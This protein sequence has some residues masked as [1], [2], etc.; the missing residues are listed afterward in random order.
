MD[1]IVLGGVLG[2]AM[3]VL[4]TILRDLVPRRLRIASD[5]TPWV[6][7]R[8]RRRTVRIALA[9]GRLV[10]IAGAVVLLATVLLVLLGTGDGIALAVVTGLTLVGL[11]AC[12]GWVLWYRYQE[13]SGTI[14]RRQ[15]RLIASRLGPA[16][17]PATSRP[18]PVRDDRPAARED[19][20][21]VHPQE[22]QRRRDAD[23][24]DRQPRHDRRTS[25]EAG[26][27]T[28]VVDDLLSRPP[29]RRGNSSTRGDLQT[30]QRPTA[31]QHDRS[32]SPR[33]PPRDSHRGATQPPV[34]AERPVWDTPSTSR[35]RRSESRP[36]GRAPRS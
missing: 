22:R 25:P 20:R 17:R 28:S 5:D 32:E 13:S 34:L 31:P 23:R 15:M 26:R 1:F 4:G 7:V 21:P 11:A 10:T 27:S 35:P 30:N 18:I 33:P 29:R 14:Q 6:E 24:D 16:G 8:D 12:L 2:A 36:T 3:I 19:G 9:G